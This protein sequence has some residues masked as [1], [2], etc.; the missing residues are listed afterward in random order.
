MTHTAGHVVDDRAAVHPHADA[1]A[2]AVS[3]D[4]DHLW[5]RLRVVEERVRHAVAVRRAGDPDPDDP[6]RGQYLTPR[7][8]PA[9]WT[10]RAASAYPRTSRGSRPPGPSSTAS[11]GGSGCPRWTSTCSWSR[12]HPTSTRGSSGSTA[13]STT[14]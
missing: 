10:S 3:G 4:V 5:T 6:Y 7:R 12:W 2:E 1:A 13:T 8:R 9:S 11:P 14:T